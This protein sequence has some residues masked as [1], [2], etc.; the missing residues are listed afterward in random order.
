MKTS[1]NGISLIKKFESL[2]DGDLSIIGLQPK[3]D[4]IGIWTEGYGRAMRDNKGKFLK[5]IE[6]KEIAYDSITIHNEEQ[7]NKAL[8]EDLNPFELQVSR[9][10]KV[11]LNQSQ[12]DSLVSY[13]YNTGGSENLVKLINKKAPLKDIEKWWTTHYITG[14]GKKLP[15]LILRR[16]KE[17]NLFKS[18]LK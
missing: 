1:K 5:G 9:Q 13:F 10:I 2:H 11:P 6:S 4:P 17:F 8:Q 3:M 18:E 14:N 15:G 16:E 12:F 7:A